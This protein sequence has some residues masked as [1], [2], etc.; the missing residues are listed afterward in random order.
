MTI[1]CYRCG[2]AHDSVQ[3]EQI[4][5]EN[6]IKKE[7]NTSVLLNVY[8]TAWKLLLIKIEVKTSWGKNELK[9][10]MLECLVNPEKEN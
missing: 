1:L 5:I 9:Q 3:E 2:K 6:I 7:L 4:C 10:L 8:C